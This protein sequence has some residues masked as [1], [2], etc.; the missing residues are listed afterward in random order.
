MQE[1]P[2]SA[3]TRQKESCNEKAAQKYSVRNNWK[4]NERQAMKN[5]L[6]HK[7]TTKLNQE[8]NAS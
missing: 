5:I 6:T 7:V 4:K 1:S 2:R 8:Q 3:T